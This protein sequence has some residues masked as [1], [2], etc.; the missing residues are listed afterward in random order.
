[1]IPNLIYE[2]N[3]R[4]NT[5]YAPDWRFPLA[6]G[7]RTRTT[8]TNYPNSKFMPK[9]GDGKQTRI[10]VLPG[11]SSQILGH[12]IITK[13]VEETVSK[14]PLRR[15]RRMCSFNRRER[16]KDTKNKSLL[17]QWGDETVAKGFYMEETPGKRKFFIE[18]VGQRKILWIKR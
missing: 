11:S 13:R 7:S 1:M 8:T 16:K 14:N 18:K 2:K 10:Y 6:F 5:D 15:R 12:H 17:C 4:R 9:S 3:E